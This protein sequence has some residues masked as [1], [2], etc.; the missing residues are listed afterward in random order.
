MRAALGCADRVCKADLQWSTL[1]SSTEGS[2]ADLCESVLLQ[3][4]TAVQ[5]SHNKCICP[6]CAAT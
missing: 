6:L 2:N 3:A 5:R 1:I 4:V